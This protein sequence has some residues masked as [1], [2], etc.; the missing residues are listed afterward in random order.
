MQQWDAKPAPRA[1]SGVHIA[2]PYP[3]S[4]SCHNSPLV[5]HCGKAAPLPLC[6]TRG[7]LLCVNI[8]LLL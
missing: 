1:G 6:L 3:A 8:I 4:S 7:F 5:R 2:L